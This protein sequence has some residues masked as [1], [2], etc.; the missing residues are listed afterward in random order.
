MPTYTNN[1]PVTGQS[2][3]ASRDLI[4]GNF[5]ILQT[6]IDQ[7][8]VD[9]NQANAGKHNKVEF[10]QQGSAPATAGDVLAMYSKVSAGAL[11]LFLR[12]AGSGTDIQMT[13]GNITVAAS[14]TT[15]LP[16][17]LQLNWGQVVPAVSPTA[18]A[19]ANNFP[20]SVFS[21]VLT[22]NNN[23]PNFSATVNAADPGGFQLYTNKTG[24]THFYIAIGN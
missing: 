23:N 12:R 24:V 11:E 17:G 1:V 9:M 5:Q 19:W 10:L 15:F 7:N 14:G 22:I 8:H 6:T 18:V 13:K 2:L 16:G 21:V 3:G 20:N 4:N